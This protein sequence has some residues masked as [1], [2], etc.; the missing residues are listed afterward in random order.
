MHGL[1]EGDRAFAIGES[2][3]VLPFEAWFGCDG[4]RLYTCREGYYRFREFVEGDDFLINAQCLRKRDSAYGAEQHGKH[5]NNSVHG[6]GGKNEKREHLLANLNGLLPIIFDR[7][8]RRIFR[9][10]GE[11]ARYNLRDCPE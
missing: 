10:A 6:I 11:C 2:E 3:G 4:R 1:V 7:W 5:N 9:R 8:E